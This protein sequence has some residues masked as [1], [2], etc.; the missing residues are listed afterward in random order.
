MYIAFVKCIINTLRYQSLITG[1]RA[2]RGHRS[3]LITL[4][5]SYYLLVATDLSI[6]IYELVY[7]TPVYYA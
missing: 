1:T 6:I 5:S 4:T 7:Y 2:H 3:L